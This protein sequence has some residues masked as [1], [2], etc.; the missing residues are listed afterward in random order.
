VPATILNYVAGVSRV[1]ARHFA[2]AITLAGLPRTAPYALLGAGLAGGSP[3][4]LLAA[5]AAAGA[6]GAGGALLAWRLR[7]SAS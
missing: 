1:R 6:V 7:Q 4:A 2:A 3:L 5:T